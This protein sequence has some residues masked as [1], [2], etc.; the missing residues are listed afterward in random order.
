MAL[1]SLLHST[2]PY[3]TLL[4]SALL[5]CLSSPTYRPFP[6]VYQYPPSSLL[7]SSSSLPFPSHN[8]SISS[9]LSI[10]LL[11][12][13]KVV[14][15]TRHGNSYKDKKEEL[16]S[17]GFNFN[18]QARGSKYAADRDITSC[19]LTPIYCTVLHYAV[20]FR[21]ALCCTVLRSAVLCSTNF[22][23]LI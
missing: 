11:Y 14:S 20:L 15:R 10:L 13:G 18:T 7:S 8:L 4:Y 3:S 19:I 23:P 1:S 21:T 17:L 2:I 16:I 9:L 5:H 12:E 22:I 6:S